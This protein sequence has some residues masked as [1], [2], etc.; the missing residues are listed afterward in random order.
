MVRAV[1]HFEDIGGEAELRAIIDDF[2]DRLFDDL[3]IGFMFQRASRER[4]KRFE[5]QHA[6]EH[7]GANVAYEGRALSQA[8]APHRIMGGQFDRRKKIL[9]NT[10]R[11]HGAPEHVIA[12]WLAHTESLRPLVTGQ[13]RGECD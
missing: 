12:A 10:L 2:V 4:I 3:M 5:Y 11:D 7:L 9:E 8:H 1:T 6:A 13:P